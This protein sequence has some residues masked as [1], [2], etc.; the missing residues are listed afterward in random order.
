MIDKARSMHTSSKSFRIEPLRAKLSAADDRIRLNH[1]MPPQQG[2]APRIRIAWRWIN[3]LWGSAD[4]SRGA[5][6]SDCLGSE[7]A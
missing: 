4:R 2:I 3:T 1:W 7:P 6:L 5:A